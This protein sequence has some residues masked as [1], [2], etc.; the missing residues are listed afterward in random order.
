M[1]INWWELSDVSTTFLQMTASKRVFHMSFTSCTFVQTSIEMLS[2]GSFHVISNPT[3][4]LS[5]TEQFSSNWP[6]SIPKSSTLDFISGLF[7]AIKL[8]LRAGKPILHKYQKG[9]EASECSQHYM[10]ILLC[11]CIF[12]SEYRNYLWHIQKLQI[13]LWYEVNMLSLNI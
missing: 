8:L 12:G 11:G 4:D 13:G 5:W 1:L 10:G 3:F 2:C 7:L 6:P 9:S